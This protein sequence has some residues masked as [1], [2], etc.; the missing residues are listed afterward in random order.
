MMNLKDTFGK[1]YRIRM[2]KSYAAETMPGK[3]KDI[4]WYYEIDGRNGQIYNHSETEIQFW[5]N[6]R[7]RSKKIKR[8]HPHWEVQQFCD[9]GSAWVLPNAMIG[10]AFKWIKP[11]K[12]RIVDPK[13]AERLKNYQFKHA[14][15]N[16]KTTEIKAIPPKGGVSHDQG[17]N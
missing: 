2:D 14:T 16:A 12:H 5:I 13:Q 3:E 15:Q 4:A 11:R 1:R 6:G 9:E 8:L 17:G 7:R 10:E